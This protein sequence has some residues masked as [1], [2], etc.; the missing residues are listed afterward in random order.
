MARNAGD[1]RDEEYHSRLLLLLLE[2]FYLEKDKIIVEGTTVEY[3]FFLLKGT[4][5]VRMPGIS[6]VEKGAGSYFHNAAASPV[7]ESFGVPTT[8]ANSISAVAASNCHIYK[9]KK[10]SIEELVLSFPDMQQ[11][12]NELLLI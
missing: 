9:L 10:S 12:L 11:K 7:A 6:P 5:I 2:E 8:I 4:A 1:G 3:I